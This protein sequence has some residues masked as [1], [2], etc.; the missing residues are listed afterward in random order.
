MTIPAVLN[1]R[2]LDG[3]NGFRMIGDIAFRAIGRTVTSLG[4]VNGDGIDDIAIASFNFTDQS[5]AAFVVFGS[6]SGFPADLD[7]GALDGTN[8]FV[9]FS[10]E[11]HDLGAGI[12]AAGDVNGDGLMDILVNRPGGF[13]AGAL[14]GESYIIFGSSAGFDP[15]FPV[16][17]LDGSN[18]FA[19]TGP[20][21][22][23]GTG[24]RVSGAGDVNSDGRDD[25]M[26]TNQV[27]GVEEETT[28]DG[29]IVYL[30]F[31]GQEFSSGVFDIGTL[32]S[33]QGLVITGLPTS[34]DD[35]V[36]MR[37]LGDVNGDGIDDILIGTEAP[38]PNDPSSTG[39]AYVIYGRASGLPAALDVSELDGTNG[40]AI[41]PVNSDGN[42]ARGIGAAGDFNGDGLA[43]FIIADPFTN[44]DPA[45][46]RARGEVYVVFGTAENTGPELDLSN[47]DGTNGFVIP[48]IENFGRI[49]FG[50][51]SAG[52]VN[53]DGFDDI[54]VGSFNPD[55]G[56]RGVSY[57]IFG[58][59]SGF[60]ASFDLT[61]LDGSNGL[62]LNGVGSSDTAGRSVGAAGDING[63]GFDDFLVG[64]IGVDSSAGF[65]VGA[66]YAVFGFAPDEAVTRIGS[67]VDQ[68]ILGGA[69]DDTL[70]GLGGDDRLE[71]RDGNDAL[72]GRAGD[73]VLLG[74]TGVD[75]LSGGIGNDALDG[76]DQA[77]TLFGDAGDDILIGGDGADWM[78]G[79]ADNDH[80]DGGFGFDRLR[81]G[82]GDDTLIGGF[83]FDIL[84]GN[85][86]NDIIQ[87]DN[88]EDRLI[89][90]AGRDT[91]TGGAHADT[92]VFRGLSDSGLFSSA[93]R[94]T[95]FTQGED[96]IDL[97]SIDA[98]AGVGNDAFTFIG[99]DKFSGTAGELRFFRANGSTF[100]VA[101]VDGDGAADFSI[102][103]TGEIEVLASDF[104][105]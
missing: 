27:R 21:P 43:D 93:D 47:L 31:G 65:S 16:D 41:G 89:G 10:Q 36:S 25:F 4:D 15:T 9:I 85:M 6:T 55:N 33:E 14:P 80:I 38:T 44:I 70:D 53:G 18:G 90:G 99:S 22:D 2:D 94:I 34:G 68:T 20:G 88:G 62:R 8:G 46:G 49:G 83:G 45:T 56:D 96:I 17:D 42:L 84:E 63:D 97:S 67:A 1:L 98:I 66:V 87:G 95:D 105:L 29:G 40:F 104:V 91:L 77:D 28:T 13:G 103:L 61:T 23:I 75:F 101:D 3:S 102:A 11:D 60:G 30:L 12:A 79:R 81:G 71:G 35:D 100:V 54:I 32:T 76:G 58:G 24:Y 78:E 82:G 39:S 86:G 5:S 26:V 59:A 19:I 51:S 92:F 48:G 50:V 64:A 57:V 73:D 7:L 72:L 37:N 69:F 52:D 74:G